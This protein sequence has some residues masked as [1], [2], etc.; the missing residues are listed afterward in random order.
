MVDDEL[1][2]ALH[3]RGEP[4][5]LVV[6]DV[7]IHIGLELRHPEGDQLAGFEVLRG[8]IHGQDRIA[9]IFPHHTG[10]DLGAADLQ[11]W[12]DN[13]VVL[14]QQAF[15][16]NAVAFASLGENTRIGDQLSQGDG[17]AAGGQL[18]MRSGDKDGFLRTAQ[19]D[20]PNRGYTAFHP[21]SR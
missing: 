6:D 13:Q 19:R 17:L 21:Q 2:E 3:L 18:G 16:G 9:D 5:I 20:S 11:N 14:R 8:D 4:F 7:L 15:K 10:N 12:G 1:H